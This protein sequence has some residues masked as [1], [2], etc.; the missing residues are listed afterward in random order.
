MSGFLAFANQTFKNPYQ[1]IW[2]GASRASNL[3]PWTWTDSTP[4]TITNWATG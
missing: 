2:I 4:V 1:S 3:T